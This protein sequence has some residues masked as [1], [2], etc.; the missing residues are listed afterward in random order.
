MVEGIKDV[1]HLVLSVLLFWGAFC[2]RKSRTLGWTSRCP[3]KIVILNGIHH[4]MML[5]G[6]PKDQGV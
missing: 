4:S 5:F 2:P 1:S 3:L 6:G